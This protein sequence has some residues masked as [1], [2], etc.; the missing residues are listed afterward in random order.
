MGANVVE[1]LQGKLFCFLLRHPRGAF[2]E[3]LQESLPVSYQVKAPKG[4]IYQRGPSRTFSHVLLSCSYARTSALIYKNKRKYSNY[5]K[6]NDRRKLHKDI[7]SLKI[8]T[9]P[10]PQGVNMALAKRV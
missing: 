2:E 8:W 9:T 7:I 4:Y 6:R 10:L 5:F 1:D 3:G